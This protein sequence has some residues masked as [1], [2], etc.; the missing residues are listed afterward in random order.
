MRRVFCTSSAIALMVVS[1]AAI[2]QQETEGG[3]GGARVAEQC[4]E[5]IRAFSEQARRDGYGM[6]GPAGYG[7]PAPPAGGW[8][9]PYGPRRELHAVLVAADVFA[10]QGKEEACQTVL[11]ELR[12]LYD[13]RM[14]RL[15]EAG[16]PP[17][18]VA[19]WRQQQLAAARPVEELEGAIRVENVVGADLRNLQDEDLG[20]IEDVMLDEQGEIAYA[21]VGHS[22]FLGFGEELTAVR[23]EDLRAMPAL[24][25]FVLDVPAEVLEEAPTVDQEVFANLDA[26]GERRQQIES[27]WDEHM[28]G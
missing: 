24:D 8:Y 20:D 15:E 18:E 10:R 1:S 23:W 22:G 13:A 14:Q 12:E 3:E 16:V 7:T 27:F 9:G 5:D 28:A 25:T 26:Y 17:D 19:G 21:L 6:V 11:A 2:A 4:L